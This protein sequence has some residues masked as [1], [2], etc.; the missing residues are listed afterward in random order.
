MYKLDSLKKN[1][2][3]RPQ[4]LGIYFDVAVALQRCYESERP[5]ESRFALIR[6]TIVLSKKLINVDKE[7][8]FLAGVYRWLSR[9]KASDLAEFVL[10][11]YKSICQM[12]SLGKSSDVLNLM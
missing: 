2:P 1:S 7:L 12:L 5:L 4:K 8:L 11:E 3:L 10:R 9:S 6:D